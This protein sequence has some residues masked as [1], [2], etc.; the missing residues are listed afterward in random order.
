M[1]LK[2][3]NRKL[4]SLVISAQLFF[5]QF[6]PLV[7]NRSFNNKSLLYLN[8]KNRQHCRA[9]HIYTPEIAIWSTN[10]IIG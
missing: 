10:V 1:L 3:L 4:T 8:T 6:L 9:R 2:H 7:K 5:F